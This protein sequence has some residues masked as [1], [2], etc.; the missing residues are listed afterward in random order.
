MC[1]KGLLEKYK[2][3][4]F[5]KAV[6]SAPWVLLRKLSFSPADAVILDDAQYRTGWEIN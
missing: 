5:L 2:P 4:V 1:G 6:N 3:V